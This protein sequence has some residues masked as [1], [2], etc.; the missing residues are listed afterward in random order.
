MK[1]R[2]TRTRAVR[3]GTAEEEEEAADP[4]KDEE[5]F[6]RAD[7]REGE[8]AGRGSPNEPDEDFVRGEVEGRRVDIGSE[9]SCKETGKTRGEWELSTSW[10]DVYETE[11]H[12]CYSRERQG[13]WMGREK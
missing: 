10:E 13:V 11:R 7:L 3:R 4:K 5:D 1:P 2:R 8:R 6:L 12:S 9:A